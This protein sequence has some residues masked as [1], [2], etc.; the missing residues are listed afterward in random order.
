MLKNNWFYNENAKVQGDKGEVQGQ[1]MLKINWFCKGNAKV[2]GHKGWPLVVLGGEVQGPEM[3]KKQLVL[4]GKRNGLG[5]QG[6]GLGTGHV[7]NPLV[8]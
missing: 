2:Q 8:L 1:D 5:R 7:E 3:L 4:Y 6:R